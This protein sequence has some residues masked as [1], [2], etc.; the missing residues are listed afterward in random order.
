MRT[1]PNIYGGG[2]NA[3]INGVRFEQ[4]TKLKTLLKSMND[5][6][7]DG[8]DIYYQGVKS[9]EVLS[10]TKFYS[11]LKSKQVDYKKIITKKINPDEIVLCN[12]TVYIIEKKFQKTTGSVDEKLQTCDFK[13][14]QFT[15][16]V[17]SLELNVEYI[18]VLNDWFR[19]ECYKDVHDYILSVGC[20]Y[21][22]NFVPL[23]EI[24][25]DFKTV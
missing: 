19:K 17:T 4:H 25:L 2:I 22:F 9:A 8:D 18:Y 14:K 6:F 10:G 23:S 13:K 1:V 21:F 15:K 7:I 24:G 3:N 11:W 12:N 5:F 16:L 20:K